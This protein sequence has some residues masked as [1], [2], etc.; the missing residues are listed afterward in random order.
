MLRQLRKSARYLFIPSEANNYHPK[1]IQNI[2]VTVYI[3]FLLSTQGAVSVFSQIYPNVLG[4]AT[5]ISVNK[6]YE[7][8]NQ[9]REEN[10]LL[11]LNLS[12]ELSAAAYNKAQNMFEEGYWAH[13]S[14]T[15]ATPW[16]FIEDTGYRYIYAGENLAK[17]FN[18]SNDVLEAWMRSETHRTN[19]LKPEY[20]DI[21]IA[22]VNGRLLGR[23]T[24]LVVQE[25]AA[26]SPNYSAFTGQNDSSQLKGEA[27]REYEDFDAKGK[28]GQSGTKGEKEEKILSTLLSFN[29][30]FTRTVS[31]ILAEFM[32]VVLF[33]D[34]VYI[35]KKKT[36]R[37]TG[38]SIFHFIFLGSLLAAVGFT[39]F[40]AIL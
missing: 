11:S 9:K 6:I 40:G 13:I 29:F 25:F 31:L 20:T 14:P 32:L 5:D 19:I 35:W 28:Q 3:L 17:D 38:K 27:S 33:I 4:Y 36:I 26:R 15:G 2:A 7:M 34:S 23:D 39:G 16:E 37:L 24:T 8:V 1:S 12:F 18:Y 30:R 10:G 21:G 22:V